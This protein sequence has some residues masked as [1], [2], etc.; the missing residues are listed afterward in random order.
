[1]YFSIFYIFGAKKK[2]NLIMPNKLYKFTFSPPARLAWLAAKIY[3]VPTEIIDIDLSTAEQLDPEFIKINPRHEVPAFDHNGEYITQSRSI[4]KYFHENFNKDADAN[5]HWYPS[6]VEER[7]KVD[8]WLNWSDKRHMTFC[9][10]PLMHAIST[11][12][13]P[14]RENYG[15]IMV[16]LGRT[17]GSNAENIDGMKTCISEAETMLSERNIE[18]VEDLNLGDLAVFFESSLAFFLLPDIKYIDYPAFKNLYD[19]IRKIPEFDQIDQEFSAFTKRVKDLRNAESYPTLF[20]YVSEIW[21]TIKLIAYV[22]WNGI[23]F[24]PGHMEKASSSG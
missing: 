22:K 12:G 10:P 3:K 15:I 20:T 1:L 23:P 4:A 18:D 8:E 11:Y 6:N 21:S 24:G 14:W 16:I 17:M 9:K 2:Q 7:A 13:M 5:E 19:V